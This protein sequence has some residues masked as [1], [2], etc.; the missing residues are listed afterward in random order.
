MGEDGE[1]AVQPRRRRGWVRWLLIGLSSLLLAGIVFHAPLLRG[2]I[3]SLGVKIAARQNLK[4]DFA[5][6]GDPLEGIVVRQLR[7][8]ATG[9]SAVRAL[10]LG[11]ARVDYS[12]PDLVFHGV[13]RTLK[14]VEA[15]DLTAVIDP[16]QAPPRP[17]PPPN[18]KASL[19]QFFPERLEAANVN[20]TVVGQ[21]KPITLQNLNL[22]LYPEREGRLEIDRIEVPGVHVWTK[23]HAATSYQNRNLVLRSLRLDEENRFET[24]GLDAS[25]IAAQKLQLELKGEIGGGRVSA[26]MNLAAEEQS[27][28]TSVQLH[29][30]QVSLGKLGHYF[31]QPAR[32]FT[33]QIRE[34]KVEARGKL[35]APRSWN[36]NVRAFFE[37]PGETGWW[38]DQAI[39]EIEAANGVAT[40]R[41]A[42]IDQGTNHLQLQG[43]TVLPPT[44]SDF[45]RTPGDF[46]FSVEAPDLAKLTAFLTP[47]ASGNLRANGRL[48]TEAQTLRLDAK[49]SGNL[50]EFQDAAAKELSAT[51][52]AARALPPPDGK[53]EVSFYEGLRT[54]LQLQLSGVAWR[55]FEVA[56]VRARAQ[57]EGRKMTLSSL[58]VNQ[59]NNRFTARGTLQLPAPGEEI[60]KQPADLEFEW[61]APQLGDYWRE[62]TA[63][64]VT[65]EM[66]GN[67]AIT[68]RHGFASGAI[69]LFGNEITARKLVVRQLSAQ[70][71][72]SQNRFYLNNLT[73]SLNEKDYLSAEG[74]IQLQ[75]PFP[76]SGAVTANLADLATFEP[77]LA[78]AEKKTPLGGSL[79]LNW[80]GEGTAAN[81]QNRGALD[82]RLERG[83]YAE[84][85]NLQAKVEAH[86]TPQELAVPIIYLGSNQLSFQAILQAKGSQLELTRIQIDQGQAK[87]ATA[88]AS[89][90]FTWSNLGT[91]RPVVPPQGSV[92]VNFQSEN[93]DLTRLFQDLGM[94][95]PATGQVTIKLDAKGPL[96]QLQANLDLQLQ[97]LQTAA[98]QKLEPAKIDLA[99]RL[100]NNELNLLGKIQQAKIQPVQIDARLPLNVSELIARHELNPETPVRAR[101]QM[102][103][104]SV[105]FVR[106]FVPA[107]RQVDGTAAIDVNIGGTIAHPAL[108]GAA[109]VNMNVARFENPSLPAL[110]NFRAQLNF[111][112]N[113]LSFDRFGGDLA[114]G[115]FTAR[116]RVSFLKLTE[117]TLDLQLNANSVLVARNDNLTARV[118]AD[119]RVQGPLN[120]AT[121]TGR[122]RTT[123]SRFFKNIEIIPIALPGRPA[124]HTELPADRPSLSFPNPPLRDWKFDLVVESKEPFLIRGN[125]AAGSAII[126]MKVGGTGLHPQ[127][128]GQVRLENFEATLPFSTL[129]ISLGF[130]YFDPDDPFNPRIEMQG[131]SLIRDYTIHA[132]IYGTANAPQAVFSSEPP[133]PQEDI[134]SLLATG[135]TREE[136]TGDNNV[137]ASRAALL[138]VKELYHKIFKKNSEPPKNDSFFNRLNVQFGNVDPRT[139]EQTAT[140]TFK[141]DDHFLL[142]GDLGVQGGF[143]GLVKYLIR[144]R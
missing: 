61:S 141:V 79:V 135:T 74:W 75:E 81:F 73:A 129:T 108:S 102:P 3:R 90:P 57:G 58:G 104:S 60:T 5:L 35:D 62:Q 15:R 10:E 7:A 116:G 113:V 72:I 19:P 137:L 84:L 99:L 18:E 16:A 40:V 103:R 123:N 109:E 100:Q 70:A 4:L 111:R 6:E 98:V 21:P 54:D 105:N 23:V 132:Y 39:I 131:T 34:M 80:H 101:V 85:Q 8:R 112:D 91:G 130:L 133:L 82:L 22:G 88:Y 114:G 33:G 47:P 95:P 43:T 53:R 20:L 69:N 36:G 97:N 17:T 96:D 37:K 134:I 142:I 12:L 52:S 125:L 59:G 143:R 89:M 71:T 13:S 138:L 2:L 94:K 9:P 56:E 26:R 65:G 140:A 29:A 110:T 28:D 93:L 67:G 24:V 49:V 139:G 25:K 144:F 1:T 42:R 14:N 27:F 68:T 41:N 124:P 126:D 66:Q 64:Q 87:Y 120:S 55:D 32:Q 63:N 122:V 119:V 127:L 48:R 76:Y 118:D 11:F 117:P 115:P 121:V 50:I 44:I 46:Q 86:Y 128:Q 83:R 38:L 51:V 92:T 78:T 77:L 31:V 107:M 136:L 106:E 45:G 30:T